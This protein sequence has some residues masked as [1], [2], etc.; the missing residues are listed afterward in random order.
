METDGYFKLMPKL[1]QFIWLAYGWLFYFIIYLNVSI[2]M[3]LFFP[4][5]FYL[6]L[7]FLFNHTHWIF[8]HEE[9]VFIFSI[10][11]RH[12]EVFLYPTPCKAITNKVQL[13]FYKVFLYK[14]DIAQNLHI[15]F[16]IYLFI[17]SFIF[18]GLGDLDL[19]KPKDVFL[20]IK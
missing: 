9:Y 6:C 14:V 20:R 5:N 13:I 17:Q 8:V 11:S 15:K 12:C 19:F 1:H 3:V 10:I 18:G 16:S 2:K 4:D 7:C